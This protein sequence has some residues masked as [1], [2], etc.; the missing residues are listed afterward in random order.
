MI[1]RKALIQK[2]SSCRTQ[3]FILKVGNVVITYRVSQAPDAFS[4]L[5]YT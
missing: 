3:T 5:F 4:L 1:V 2:V